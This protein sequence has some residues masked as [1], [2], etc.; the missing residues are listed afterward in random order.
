MATMATS[1]TKKGQVTIPV[2]V[3]K[4]LG[5]KPRDRVVFEIRDTEVTIRP[6]SS[7]LLAGFGAVKPKTR[8]EDFELMRKEVGE[9]L[10]EG[11]L[12]ELRDA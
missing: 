5:L 12:R 4:A 1:M 2:E 9:W 10:A 7:D 11:M 6:A 8:P 3:R